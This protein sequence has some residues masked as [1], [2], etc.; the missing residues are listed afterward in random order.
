MARKRKNRTHVQAP[1][2]PTE[3]PPRSF[4]VKSGDVG[5]PVG[6]L[7]QDLRRVMS[8]NTAT[9]LRERK[10]NKLR[11]YVALSGP[12]AVSHL[13]VFA[14]TDAGLNLRIGKLPRGPTVGFRVNS[15]SLAHDIAAMLKHPKTMSGAMYM[16]APLLVLNNFPA[17]RAEF[18]LL[19]TVL[20]NMF[21]AINVAKLKI[22]QTRR[23]VLF[24]YNAE[25]DTIDFRHYAIDVKA[26]GV[27]KGVKK[28]IDLKGLPNLSQFAD[29]SEYIRQQT[30][31]ADSDVED[32]G[33]STVE[34]PQK[35][36]G[37]NNRRAEQRAIKLTEL[38]PRLDLNLVKIQEG[39]C[40]GEVLYHKYVTKSADEVADMRARTAAREADKARRKANQEANVAKKKAAKEARRAARRAEGKSE[41]SDSDSEEDEV[42]E[43]AGDDEIDYLDAF[44]GAGRNPAAAS[45]RNEDWDEEMDLEEDSDAEH[46]GGRAPATVDSDSD[47]D[48]EDED[49]RPPPAK[50]QAPA[51]AKSSSRAAAKGKK[52]K[53]TRR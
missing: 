35:Y 6:H 26:T 7:I 10:V 40:T 45:A 53:P 4:V 21:P 13:L 50:K 31:A 52:P 47:D 16:S 19:S 15:Y 20:H 42:D 24:S 25:S 48:D 3:F 39:L 2:D 12:L 44:G 34:L 1:E 51:P 9:K 41:L 29:I 14:R 28:I 46:D 30:N 17:D 38:G 37:R 36:A 8:P 33:A 23:V 43:A 11:D 5:R 27:T 32:G 22:N 18:K 49:A